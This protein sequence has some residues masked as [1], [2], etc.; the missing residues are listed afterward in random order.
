[1]Y[2]ENLWPASYTCNLRKHEHHFRVLYAENSAVREYMEAHHGMVWSRSKF[3]EIC[4]VDYVTSNLAE[5]FNSKI[6]PVKGLMLWQAFDKIRQM[7]MIKMDL[8][9]RIA[10]TQYVGH[11]IT[12]S[13]I[14][15]LHARARGLRMKCI[16]RSTHKVEVTYTDTKNR[17][18][19]YPVDLSSK[20][21]SCRQWQI[22]GQPCIHALFFMT[23]IGDE[24]GEVD[25]YVSEYFSVAKFKA[26][27]AE[28]VPALLGKD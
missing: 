17:E 26:T 16:R 15:A 28:N 12:P 11:V 4:K 25:Q 7:T 22:R 19:R 21:C 13:M 6:K 20:T 8:R 9:R 14:K 10:D 3:N 1:V 18:C 23:V 2:D 27:Y 5:C 24:I